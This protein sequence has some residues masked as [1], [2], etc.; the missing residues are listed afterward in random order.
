MTR[1]RYGKFLKGD[2]AANLVAFEPK[3]HA[4][5]IA[6]ANYVAPQAEAYMRENAPWT[7][8]TGNA[9]QGLGARVVV[10]PEVVSIVLYHSVFYGIFLEAR[11]GGKYAIIEP[12]IA[13][14]AP[15]YAEAVRR[16]ALAVAV[17][18]L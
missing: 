15:K 5:V 4:G 17:R 18:G 16:L 10:N 2:L 12:T 14:M 7:D 13:V 3:L 8:R 1:A 9:R 6:A 11:W